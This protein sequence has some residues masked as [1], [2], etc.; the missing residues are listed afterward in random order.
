MRQLAGQNSGGRLSATE[1][2]EMRS[3]AK[4]GRLL[5]LLRLRA[6]PVLKTNIRRPGEALVDERLRAVRIR[7]G[8]AS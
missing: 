2:D 6:R 1:R 7:V 5:G 4:A 8:G 3:Y